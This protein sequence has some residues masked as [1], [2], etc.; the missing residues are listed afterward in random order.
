MAYICQRFNFEAIWASIHWTLSLYNWG[1]SVRMCQRE[2]CYFR[3]DMGPRLQTLS[4][5]KVVPFLR[6]F[7][8]KADSPSTVRILGLDVAPSYVNVH[9]DPPLLT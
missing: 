4:L 5:T 3:L 6:D 9:T 2:G 8:V 1:D 7:L